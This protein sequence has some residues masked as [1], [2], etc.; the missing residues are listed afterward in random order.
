[1]HGLL[2]SLPGTPVLYYGDEIGM[3]DN[4]YLGDRNG[5][6]TPMQW[7][8]D[9]NAGFSE[10]NPQRLYLPV[11]IDPQCHY[12]SV[13]VAAQ[14]DNPD[15]LLR[16]VRRIIALRKR[17]RVFGR[18]RIEFVRSENPSVLAFVRSDE[19]EQVLVV[20]NLSRF[21]QFVEL[22]LSAFKGRAPLELFGHRSF[23]AIGELPYLVTLSPYSFY[24]FALEEPRSDEEAAA[25][26]AALPELRLTD[27]WWSGLE[28]R[29]R[30]IFEAAIPAMLA[31]HRWYGAKDR[32]VQGATIGDRFTLD[33]EGTHIELLLVD[34]EF[35]EGE[36]AH[37]LLPVV[38][39]E[40]K[41][42]SD[43]EHDHPEAVLARTVSA[44]GTEG[45]L[46]DAHYLEEF[47]RALLG[48]IAGRRRRTGARGVRACS[49]RRR[50]AAPACS[51]PCSETTTCRCGRS[52]RSS[53]TRR[54]SPGDRTGRA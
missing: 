6:R 26:L 17:H 38:V 37:Y 30:R 19:H 50:P 36:A 43:V 18:G 44:G 13:N 7:T 12:E 15:S 5:V 24:W 47:G 40:G 4:V 46:L 21:A 34:V 31:N 48:M 29:G 27:P 35:F 51:P 22:D 32:R 33:A 11:V 9:R 25:E 45:R 54:C 23:P 28:G 39:L 1:M 3:G 42:A 53:P 16:W 8:G 49:A 41:S 2:L 14:L 52:G 10:A 20:A